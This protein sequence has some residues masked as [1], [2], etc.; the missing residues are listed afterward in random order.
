[1]YDENYYDDL[2]LIY[3][4]KKDLKHNKELIKT[5]YKDYEKI[6]GEIIINKTKPILNI[7]GFNVAKIENKITEPM[8]V[9][10]LFINNGNISAYY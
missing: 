1:M 4:N 8:K 5:I 3:L 7:N 2:K 9:K 10:K 6:Y